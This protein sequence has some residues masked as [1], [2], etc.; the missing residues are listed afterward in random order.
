MST[1]HIQSEFLFTPKRDQLWLGYYF[2]A[3]SFLILSIKGVLKQCR[4]SCRAYRYVGTCMKGKCLWCKTFLPWNK[5]FLN[6]NINLIWIDIKLNR[7]FLYIHMHRPSHACFLLLKL[8]RSFIA[9]CCF[10][11]R[12]LIIEF[13]GCGSN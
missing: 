11:R 13:K 4:K 3:Y 9:I 7:W 12:T 2:V 5:L 1:G 8:C 6:L 10:A